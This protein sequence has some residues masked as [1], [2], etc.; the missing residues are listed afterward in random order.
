[1]DKDTAWCYVCNQQV[2]FTEINHHVQISSLH[3]EGQHHWKLSGETNI[4]NYE[5]SRLTSNPPGF[6]S[7][8]FSG[9]GR[10]LV[11]SCP[12]IGDVSC[13]YPRLEC[14]G[15]RLFYYPSPFDPLVRTNSSSLLMVISKNDH[16][17]ARMAE[18]KF[19]SHGLY[20]EYLYS[21]SDLEELEVS[22][23]DPGVSVALYPNPI[24]QAEVKFLWQ[25]SSKPAVPRAKRIREERHGEADS[26]MIDLE[27]LI[28][29]LG[30]D[31]IPK[32]DTSMPWIKI[33]YE[34]KK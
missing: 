12:Q 1:V 7:Q 32:G 24:F 29:E 15:G 30:S 27:H 13:Q 25:E 14:H 17:I 9:P 11:Q 16:H 19:N 2:K 34:P 20:F 33:E 18:N 6:P 4:S 31:I 26:Q 28:L 5:V 21:A 10:G 8:L 3:Q 22:D 23:M